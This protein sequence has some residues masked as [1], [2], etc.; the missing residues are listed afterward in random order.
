M[1]VST[2]YFTAWYMAFYVAATLFLIPYMAWANE[3]TVDTR[4]KT[5]VF[6]AISVTQQGGAILFFVLP[7]LPYF[8]STEITPEVLK[9][10]VVLGGVVLVLGLFI[11]LKIV[12]SWNDDLAQAHSMPIKLAPKASPI[13]P[14]IR[15]VLRFFFANK[16]FL[17]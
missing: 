9:V 16:P 11:A 7:L 12:P 4:E 17:L 10:A 13:V 14:Q 8:V 5:L 15:A 1:E 3:F 2:V 6:S